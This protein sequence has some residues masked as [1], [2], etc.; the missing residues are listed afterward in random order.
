MLTGSDAELFADLVGI[1]L[2]VLFSFGLADD[3]TTILERY[4]R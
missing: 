2:I 4:R 3:V 1:V